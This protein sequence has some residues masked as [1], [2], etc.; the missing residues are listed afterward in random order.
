MSHFKELR[1]FFEGRNCGLSVA[2]P[3]NYGLL[4]KKNTKGLILGQ[5][6]TRVAKIETDCK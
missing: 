4:R 5:K 2:K 6:G 1:H 3:K